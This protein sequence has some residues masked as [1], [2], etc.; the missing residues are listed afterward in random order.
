L[1][2]VADGELFVEADA[3][4]EQVDRGRLLPRVELE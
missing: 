2:L 3:R 1:A 4:L